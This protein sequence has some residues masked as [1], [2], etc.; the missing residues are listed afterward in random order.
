M[1][2]IA[3]YCYE[4][5]SLFHISVPSAIFTD[6]FQQQESPFSVSFC[7]D[8][9]GPLTTSCG[10]SIHIENTIDILTDAD[11]LIFPSWN[12]DK[13]PSANLLKI[14][15][16]ANQSNK[17]IVGLCL[18]AFILAYAGVLNHKS[19]T[20]H[21]AYGDLFKQYFPQV[22]YQEDPL[23]IQENNVMTS[24]GT[25][26]A[27]DCCLNLI[28]ELQG[29]QMANQ[30]SRMMVSAPQRNGGQKQFISRPI[31]SASSDQRIS[32]F[33]HHVLNNL[34]S[35]YSLEDAA[36]QCCMSRRSFTRHF[37]QSFGMGFKEWINQARLT[38]SQ[39]LLESSNFSITQIAEKSGFT[40]EQNYRKQFKLAYSVSPNEWRKSFINHSK[41]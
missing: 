7:A 34:S 33:T 15:N 21:W 16:D 5:I 31:L 22:N 19:A 10:V 30:V 18:G 9:I 13:Q 35:S 2:K 23:Y 8:N 14:I 17:L 38:F 25:A 12:T 29:S 6:A 39:E 41:H 4:G 37:Q 28:K 36:K 24:A 32:Q 1:K 11:I 26:A 20:T 3:I 27:I 40:T